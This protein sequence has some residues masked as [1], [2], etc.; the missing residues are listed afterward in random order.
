MDE[1]N[2]QVRKRFI[3]GKWLYSTFHLD[4]DQKYGDFRLF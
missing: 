3:M 1:I 4:E 2:L